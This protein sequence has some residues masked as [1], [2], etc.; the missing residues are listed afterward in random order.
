MTERMQFAEKRSG[1]FIA[2]GGYAI[3]RDGQSSP[4]YW[5]AYRPGS[6]GT[7]CIDPQHELGAGAGDAGWLKCVGLCELEAR[8]RLPGYAESMTNHAAR[9]APA[10]ADPLQGNTAA[11]TQQGLEL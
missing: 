9:D 7:P 2:P 3:R 1:L 4:P 10:A 6:D 11:P 5:T 8:A